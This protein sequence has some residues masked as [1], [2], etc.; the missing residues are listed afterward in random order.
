MQC[1]QITGR[2][3]S[4]RFACR[5]LCLVLKQSITMHSNAKLCVKRHR[6][7]IEAT[8][9]FDIRHRH[10]TST[11]DIRLRHST[12]NRSMSIEVAQWRS[13]LR[14]TEQDSTLYESDPEFNG[15]RSL[16]PLER[17]IIQGILFSFRT[18]SCHERGGLIIFDILLYLIFKMME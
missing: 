8:S 6:G 3:K 4:R 1:L 16:I 5:L 18:I 14:F 15:I 9:T 7:D 2:H 13:T 17:G 10:S 11:F 12:S